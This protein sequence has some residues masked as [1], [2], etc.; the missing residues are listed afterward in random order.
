[1][2]HRAF[3]LQ[4]NKQF[5]SRAALLSLHEEELRLDHS[6]LAFVANLA[7]LATFADGALQYIGTKIVDHFIEEGIVKAESA[8]RHFVDDLRARFR[9]ERELPSADPKEADQLVARADGALDEFFDLL[10]TLNP[11]VLEV[12]L[13]AG[14]DAAFAYLRND[15]GIPQNDSAFLSQ[16]VENELRAALANTKRS[17][18]R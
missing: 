12:A 5:A 2:S 4:L 15:L 9:R 10:P 13:Q 3:Y 7:T 17:G 1:M 11:A 6:L 14:R 8:L 18:A 16:A